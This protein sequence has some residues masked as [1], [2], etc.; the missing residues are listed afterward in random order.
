MIAGEESQEKRE[1][2]VV[3]T[4]V[5]EIDNFDVERRS[6]EA[7]E[8]LE[9]MF[10]YKTRKHRFSC[11]AEVLE[12]EG[13]YLITVGGKKKTASIWVDTSTNPRFWLAY[14]L[15]DASLLDRW[16]YYVS[17][18][19]VRF[20]FVWLWPTFLES[21]QERGEARGFGLDY[22]YRKFA[23]KESELTSYLKM[24]IWGGRQ[25]T[26]LYYN[27]KHSFED[28][29]ILSRVRLKEENSSPDNFAVSSLGY[30]GKFNVKGTD[31]DVHNS[32]LNHV[33]KRYE[34]EISRIEECSLRWVEKEEG[35]H[36]LEGYAIHFVPQSYRINDI[37]SFF[38]HVFGGTLPFRL[39][40]MP[41]IETDDAIIA[42]VI[43]MHVG[44]RLRFEIYP[45]LISVYLREGSCGNTVARLYTNLQHSFGAHF[46]VQSDDGEYFF[47]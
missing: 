26:D 27:L 15:S 45:D 32:T 11:T 13:F 4:F 14:S 25:T 6:A 47:E 17:K 19:S 7:V 21:V 43:D 23:D 3:K 24:Q 41:L 18:H 20:D 12:E 38:H 34:C 46:R 33:R 30:T 40:G 44:N 28:K 36:V 16:L 37:D 35:G 9:V 31:F 1:T 5:F 22:D 29:I 42:D 39:A 10:S 2:G 8:F